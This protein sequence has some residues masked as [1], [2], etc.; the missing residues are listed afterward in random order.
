L[1]VVTAWLQQKFISA[2]SPST[3]G[4]EAGDQ[5][6]AMTQS[7]QITMPL[8]MGFISLNYASG[9]SVYFVI[10]NLIGIAQYYFI[11][12]KYA[13]ESDTDEA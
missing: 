5:A 2:S 3:G 1:V 10:S 11:Q 13:D 12:R 4:G 6:Q 7:M 9:L 8:F